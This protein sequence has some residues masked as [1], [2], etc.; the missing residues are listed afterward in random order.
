M[1]RG[2]RLSAEQMAGMLLTAHAGGLDD[3]IYKRTTPMVIHLY[4]D[5]HYKPRHGGERRG[6]Q[7]K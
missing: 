7:K 1:V 6:G 5:G 4:P 3:Y 2:D